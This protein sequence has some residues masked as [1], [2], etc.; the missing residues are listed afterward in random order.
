[1]SEI[2]EALLKIA[3]DIVKIAEAL[4]K[5][6]TEPSVPEWVVGGVYKDRQGIIWFLSKILGDDYSYPL[7][8]VRNNGEKSFFE[9]CTDM[10]GFWAKDHKNKCDIVEKLDSLAS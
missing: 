9:M 1:M 3:D 7:I 4:G 10:N 6:K 8:F 5:D 2:E